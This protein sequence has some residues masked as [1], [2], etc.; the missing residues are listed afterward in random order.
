VCPDLF[1]SPDPVIEYRLEF[2]RVKLVHGIFDEAPKIL[3]FGL[4]VE[5]VMIRMGLN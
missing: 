3:F 5:I 1:T 4:Y 2:Q